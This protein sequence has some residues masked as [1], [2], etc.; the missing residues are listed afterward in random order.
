MNSRMYSSVFVILLLLG[1]SG[2]LNAA[3]PFAN[4]SPAHKML[5]GSGAI[6]AYSTKELEHYIF[7]DAGIQRY[8]NHS[9]I[10]EVYSELLTFADIDYCILIHNTTSNLPFTRENMVEVI[11]NLN[12]FIKYTK[13]IYGANESRRLDVT[14]IP[15]RKMVQR[16]EEFLQN[17][18]NYIDKLQ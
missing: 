13:K 10:R 2:A 4:Y 3:V 7:G 12:K 15:F 8:P 6:C 18:Q 17:F 14:L 1:G 5:G 9:Y 16:A 11:R